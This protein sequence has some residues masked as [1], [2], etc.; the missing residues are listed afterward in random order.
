MRLFGRAGLQP[1]FELEP[2]VAYVQLGTTLPYVPEAP[3]SNKSFSTAAEAA[4][5]SQSE[6]SA[7][8][9]QVRRACPRFGATVVVVPSRQAPGWTQHARRVRHC[10]QRAL[11]IHIACV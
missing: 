9:S 4:P 10:V 11:R 7:P 8:G 5:S 1:D 3:G 6:P 2:L